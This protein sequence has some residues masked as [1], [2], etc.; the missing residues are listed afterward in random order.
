M[1]ALGANLI[2]PFFYTCTRCL[3][4]RTL[5]FTMC[6]FFLSAALIHSMQRPVHKLSGY[7]IFDRPAGR[8]QGNLRDSGVQPCSRCHCGSL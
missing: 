8:R 5:F 4:P 1:K 3:V 7:G 2:K 6:D